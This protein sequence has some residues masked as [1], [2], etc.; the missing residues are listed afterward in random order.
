MEILVL[1]LFS[2]HPQSS[3]SNAKCICLSLGKQ[4]SIF[5]KLSFIYESIMDDIGKNEPNVSYF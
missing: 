3:L 4:W 2:Y 5:G 1:T